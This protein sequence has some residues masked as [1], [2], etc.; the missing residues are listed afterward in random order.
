[1]QQWLLR[2]ATPQNTSNLQIQNPQALLPDLHT[3]G[4]I[5]VGNYTP[6]AAGD[7][8][9]GPNHVLPTAGAA[10]YAAPLG[11]YDYYKR[12]SILQYSQQALAKQAHDIRLLAEE[13]G[14]Q[15]HAR[16]VTIRIP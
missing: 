11:V 5:F 1:M 6:E 2:T 9:A 3:A 15:A 16:S 7:Y 10:R 14:L 4:A 13:E 12:T 8:F